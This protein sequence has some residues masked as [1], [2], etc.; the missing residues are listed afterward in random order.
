MYIKQNI[1]DALQN[2]GEAREEFKKELQEFCETCVPHLG[3]WGKM[4]PQNNENMKKIEQDFVSYISSN[5]NKTEIQK[6]VL[7]LF[8]E[9]PLLASMIFLK[10]LLHSKGKINELLNSN[11]ELTNEAEKKMGELIKFNRDKALENKKNIN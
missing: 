4:T 6:E 9:L 3:L 2:K 8:K 7:E 10:S 5:D 1:A 11:N